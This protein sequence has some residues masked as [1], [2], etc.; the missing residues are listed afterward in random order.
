VLH[1]ARQAEHFDRVV[2]VE[3]GNVVEQDGYAALVGR[4]SALSSLLAQD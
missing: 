3:A 4:D 1:R 2:V